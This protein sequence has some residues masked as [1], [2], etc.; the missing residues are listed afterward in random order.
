MFFST[1]TVFTFS[2][3]QICKQIKFVCLNCHCFKH[4]YFNVSTCHVCLFQF[5]NKAKRFVHCGS[6]QF[7]IWLFNFNVSHLFL[8]SIILFSNIS[9]CIK[10]TTFQTS[11]IQIYTCPFFKIANFQNS[12]CSNINVVVFV[13]STFHFVVVVLRFK[14]TTKHKHFQNFMFFNFKNKNNNTTRLPFWSTKNTYSCDEH[15]FIF[16]IWGNPLP[17]S[18][19]GLFTTL[20]TGW[21]LKSRTRNT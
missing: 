9:T 19:V 14:Q 13:S 8:F 3:R 21:I 10:P 11:A 18:C 4:Q 2:N 12:S 16:K 15:N 20:C 17:E 1:I 7:L 6:F 5:S